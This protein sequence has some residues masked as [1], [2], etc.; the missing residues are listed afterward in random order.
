MK[1]FFG[2]SKNRNKN[3]TKKYNVFKQIFWKPLIY[4]KTDEKKIWAKKFFGPPL[5]ENRGQK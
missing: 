5:R 3:S 2:F 4:I 1:R